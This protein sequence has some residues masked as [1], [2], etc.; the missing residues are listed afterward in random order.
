MLRGEGNVKKRNWLVVALAVLLVLPA[1]P[2]KTQAYDM[3][4]AGY[5]QTVSTG[6]YH[7]MAIKTDGSL[8]AWG[9][10]YYGEL[11]DGTREDRNTS[12]KVMDGV[13]S[14]SAGGF[15]TMAIKADGSLWA[16]GNNN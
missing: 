1:M 10:N 5:F 8:W 6:G 15:H 9:S 14:V 12:I 7:S 13:T 11:G 3:G 4:K 2:I 16:W